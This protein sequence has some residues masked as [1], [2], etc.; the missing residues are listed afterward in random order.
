M[1][2]QLANGEINKIVGFSNVVEWITAASSNTPSSASRFGNQGLNDAVRFPVFIDKLRQNIWN[3]ISKPLESAYD[4]GMLPIAGT[5]LLYTTELTHCFVVSYH[6]HYERPVIEIIDRIDLP[7]SVFELDNVA[8]LSSHRAKN[9]A[10][11]LLT[12]GH[13]IVMQQGVLTHVDR[14]FD[15]NVFGPT[16]DTLL[17]ADILRRDAAEHGQTIESFLEVGSG[18]GH[19]AST[20]AAFYT[21][22][23]RF[24][25][26]EISEFASTCT[27][28]NIRQSLKY[29]HASKT[30]RYEEFYS[31]CGAFKRNVFG[32]R[33]DLVVSNPPYI[34]RPPYVTERFDERHAESVA[35]TELLECILSNTNDLL[36]PTGRM[37]LMVS[38]VSGNIVERTLSE[39]FHIRPAL[40]EQETFEVPF[41]VEEVLDHPR[42]LKDLLD[43]GTILS[44]EGVYWHSLRPIWVE[45]V[46]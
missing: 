37:L 5:V 22:I 10:K 39:A 43:S 11:N 1:Q 42:W 23:R 29:F 14:R 2:Q 8:R 21:K 34:P 33:F 4:Q 26:V 32:T 16:I 38:S 35:G 28:R 44:R 7:K 15:R 27:V 31:A 13:K 25:C 3:S 45:R 24:I 30:S 40:P 12:S 19:I 46:Q 18:S 20:V 9:H 36:T 6:M 41:D 17:L